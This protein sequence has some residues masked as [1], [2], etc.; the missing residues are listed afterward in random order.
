MYEQQS[1]SLGLKIKNHMIEIELESARNETARQIQ[2]TE[3]A[4]KAHEI[5][6]LRA[7]EVGKRALEENM[8]IEKKDSEISSLQE[9]LKKH[10]NDLLGI[11]KMNEQRESE[12]RTQIEIK[13][14]KHNQ[15]IEEIQNQIEES[16]L[17]LKTAKEKEEGLKIII[18]NKDNELKQLQ[19]NAEEQKRTQV[20]AL[21]REMKNLKLMF[22]KAKNETLER[23]RQLEEKLRLE[24][25]QKERSTFST[26]L[27][28][29]TNAFQS[30]F[31]MFSW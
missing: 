7:Q 25:E 5:V 10:Q 12:M 21:Q 11:K 26:V 19:K 29:I 24:K 9:L 20:E 3:T 14:E 30:V 6:E 1:K 27:L 2:Q 13:M 8:E 16:M 18:K 31:E 23:K 28:T 15:T 17:A 22:E 4:A